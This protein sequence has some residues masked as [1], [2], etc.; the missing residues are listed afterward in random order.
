[1]CLTGVVVGGTSAEPR[2][3]LEWNRHR[4]SVHSVG[5]GAPRLKNMIIVFLMEDVD[6]YKVRCV[7]ARLCVCFVC[8]SG[9]ER[10]V[11]GSSQLSVV[12]CRVHL[13]VFVDSYSYISIFL[14]LPSG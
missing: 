9:V 8:V 5:A 14:A 12:G 3:I 1:M 13:S 2:R 4:I 6:D 10:L 7:R 11:I